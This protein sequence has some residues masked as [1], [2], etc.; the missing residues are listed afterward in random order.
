ME[1]LHHIYCDVP[2]NLDTDYGDGGSGR[3]AAGHAFYLRNRQLNRLH[4]NDIFVYPTK[5]Q[6][7]LMNFSI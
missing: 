1:N 5:S 4:H 3:A 2:N 6:N 7:A